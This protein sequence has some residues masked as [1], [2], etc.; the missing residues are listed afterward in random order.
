MTEISSQYDKRVI[1]SMQLVYGPGFFSPGGEK[2]V[3]QIVE[4]LDLTRRPV[5]D[6]GCGLGG[7]AVTLARDHRAKVVGIDVEQSVLDIAK[8]RVNELALE[9]QITLQSVE[10]AGAL[11]FPEQT[12]GVVYAT[13]VICHMSDP[14]PFF[15]EVKR[16]LTTGGSF[17]GSDWFRNEAGTASP[18]LDEWANELRA[19]GLDFHFMVCAEFGAA[20][21]GLDFAVSL[22]E[23]STPVLCE[24]QITMQRIRGPLSERLTSILGE[25]GYRNFVKGGEARMRALTDG[26]L[27]HIR[28]HA[29]K[30]E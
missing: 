12:F 18:S 11:P 19:R 24:A 2:E 6:V 30:A 17:V 7:P 5:L 22:H 26:T 23:T 16:V 29:F 1:E 25:T 14:I 8:E 13:S 15:E 3:A 10:P 9:R 27:R 21:S 28:F 4:G 20:L